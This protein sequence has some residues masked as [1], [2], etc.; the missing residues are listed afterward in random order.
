MSLKRCK[1]QVYQYESKE[2]VVDTFYAKDWGDFLV[3]TV[4]GPIN[5]EA[6][7]QLAEDLQKYG[8]DNNKHIIVV[9]MDLDIRFFG[10][11]IEEDEK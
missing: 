6:H 4:D 5:D 9:P 3:I 8:A 2:T 10:F 1:L 11:E 7:M